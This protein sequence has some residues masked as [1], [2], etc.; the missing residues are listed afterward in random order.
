VSGGNDSPI[1]IVGCPR[2]GTS[3]LRD[4]L[5]SHPRLAFPEESHFIPTLYRAYGDP[6]DER[7]AVELAARILATGWVKAWGLPLQPPAFAGER[8]F[9]RVVARMYEAWAEK[10]GKPRWGDKTPRYVVDIPV[11]LKLFP[12]AKILHIYRDGRD[13]AL[14]W[15]RYG[16]GPRNLFTAALMWSD[17]VSAGRRAGAAAGPE[18]YREVRYEA[19]L[20]DP[21][22]IMR[23]VCAFLGE[24]FSDAVLAPS[25]LPRKNADHGQN[26]FLIGKPLPPR[27]RQTE[28]VAA[29]A[30]KWRT[31]MTPADRVLFESAAGALLTELGYESEGRVRKIAA[32]ERWMWSA[33][34]R[35]R[36]MLRRLNRKAYYRELREALGKHAAILAHRLRGKIGFAKRRD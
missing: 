29:N 32:A 11:L 9:A 33:D 21:E 34:H 35:L 36:W 15:L 24:P 7:A 10:Q 30:G 6:R 20:A 19:L 4:L 16:V 26:A 25:S 3:L 2:S 12:A 27:P 8:S 28:I 13:V 18:R 5:R 23:E 14:S 1:F 22:R 31:M 17:T